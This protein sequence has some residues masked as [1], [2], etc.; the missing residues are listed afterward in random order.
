ML[1]DEMFRLIGFIG[2]LCAASFPTAKSIAYHGVSA[3]L[4]LYQ[5][6]FSN[7]Q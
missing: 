2:F 4:L 3:F 7:I 6:R 5:I 1:F